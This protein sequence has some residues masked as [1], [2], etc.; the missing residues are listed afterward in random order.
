LTAAYSEAKADGKSPENRM[1]L[2]SDR[3]LVGSVV[4]MWARY[5]IETRGWDSDVASWSF[6]SG[7]AFDPN[8][9]ISFIRAMQAA[10]SGLVSQVDQYLVQFRTLKLELKVLLSRQE[11]Q[12]PTDLLYLERLAVLEQEIMAA[13][14][15]ARGETAQ[16]VR[17]AQEA[18]RLEGEMPFSF[19]PPF[20]DLPSAEYLGE[21]LLG[22]R[23]YAEAAA[24]FGLQLERSRQKSWSLLGLARAQAGLGNEAEARFTREKLNR[25]WA[26]AD[27]KV[28]QTD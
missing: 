10:N 24:A 17:F 15:Y 22:A 1:E 7:D 2:D 19:G 13:I 11:E 3:T 23:K 20:V 27:E 8:L 21:L 4:Q 5:V 6:N 28:K 25:I 18:S 16:A 14:E 9:T 12:S 26:G